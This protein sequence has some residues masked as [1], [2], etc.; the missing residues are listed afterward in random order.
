MSS[1]NIS[2]DKTELSAMRV[3]FNGVD[4]GGTKGGVSISVKYDLAEIVCDQ[5]GKTPIDHRVSGQAFMVK[6]ALTEIQKKSNWKVALPHAKLIT[7]GPSQS[8]LLDS[9]VGDSLFAKAQTLVL[10]PLSK[11]DSDLSGNYKIFKA[12]CK[13]AVEVKYSSSDQTVLECEFVIYPD[14]TT[15]PARYMLIGDPSLGIVAPTATQA[16]AGTGNGLMTGLVAN[17]GALTETIT[18]T[19]VAA[20][21]N[22]GTF[23]VSGSASGSLGLAVVGTPFSSSR[24]NFTIADGTTDFALGDVFTITTTAS[25]YA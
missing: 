20:A 2:P 1:A 25:N 10:H 9:K 17:T 4:L 21:V 15:N 24:V 5:L 23:H 12:A 14:P 16:F 11:D 8:L 13:S 19:L 22:G 3:E 6:F 7:S 18:A